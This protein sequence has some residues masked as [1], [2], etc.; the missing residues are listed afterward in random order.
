MIYPNYKKRSIIDKL[1]YTISS[2]DVIEQYK[3][4]ESQ[5]IFLTFSIQMMV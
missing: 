3:S 4:D 1:C 2:F 5:I